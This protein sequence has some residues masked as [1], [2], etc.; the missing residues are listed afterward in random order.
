MKEKAIIL[1]SE[2][3]IKGSDGFKFIE[4]LSFF[5]DSNETDL[6]KEQI[7]ESLFSELLD[8]FNEKDLFQFL[9]LLY[10]EEYLKHLLYDKKDDILMEIIIIGKLNNERT[11]NNLCLY[12][13]LLKDSGKTIEEIINI[14]DPYME[15]IAKIIQCNIFSEH[16]TIFTGEDK[17]KFKEYIDATYSRN[18]S[19]FIYNMILGSLISRIEN[20]RTFESSDI[21]TTCIMFFENLVEGLMKNEGVTYSDIT[22]ISRGYFC[23]VYKIGDKL[24]KLGLPKIK[25]YVPNSEYI[26][27][28]LIRYNLKNNVGKDFIYVEVNEML[29]RTNITEEDTYELYSKL[30]EQG[31]KWI[32]AKEENVGRLRKNNKSYLYG[33]EITINQKVNGF[34]SNNATTLGEDSLVVLDI[35]L[36]YCHDEAVG[37]DYYNEYEVRWEKEN[38]IRR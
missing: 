2:L 11:S 25:P 26:M 1:L 22:L 13:K 32:D 10:K 21:D 23:D 3:F 34:Y 19:V 6:I 8:M 20:L 27:Q 12:L 15:K 31:I 33:E 9:Q 30:R 14:L 16:I 38:F 37:F 36:L 7:I 4:K 24:L 18:K 35:D 29:D 17:L 5:L 28:P